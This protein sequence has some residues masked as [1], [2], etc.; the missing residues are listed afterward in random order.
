[1]SG[2][3]KQPLSVIQ[4]KGKSNHLTKDEI[5][6]RKKHE[7]SMKAKTDKIYPPERLSKK[8]RERFRELSSQLADL[9][10]FDNLDVDTLALYIESY[11]NYIRTI[12]SA[13]RMANKEMDEDFDEYAKRMRTSTQLAEL[14]R[15]LA[16]D[17]GLTIT[18]RLKLIIPQTEEETKS[19]MAKFLKQRGNDG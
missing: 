15:K 18:S 17:L 1:M 6:K 9:E 7:E 12:R 14:C 16:S 4:G 19:P 10:I 11:D 3:K 13:K 8:Q 5:V 2:R